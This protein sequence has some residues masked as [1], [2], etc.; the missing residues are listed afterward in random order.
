MGARG[1][2]TEHPAPKEWEIKSQSFIF[3]A[4]TENKKSL[5]SKKN[6]FHLGLTAVFCSHGV[7]QGCTTEELLW[8]HKSFGH[9]TSLTLA[10][11]PATWPGLRI[12]RTLCGT[13]E[14]LA[15][16]KLIGTS[17]F[18]ALPWLPH[19]PTS[20]S[21]GTWDLCQLFCLWTTPDRPHCPCD[22]QNPKHNPKD[23]PSFELK[24]KQL[25]LCPLLWSWVLPPPLW[26]PCDF[27][28]SASLQKSSLQRRMLQQIQLSRKGSFH[29]PAEDSTFQLL[30]C[31]QGAVSA[32]TDGCSTAMSQLGLGDFSCGE[33][34]DTQKGHIKYRDD[35]MNPL[36]TSG[37][38]A[39]DRFASIVCGRE[40]WTNTFKLL[41]YFCLL[42]NHC[43][44]ANPYGVCLCH[45]HHST[46]K[47]HKGFQVG[48]LQC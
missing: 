48:S 18:A 5:V 13:C 19:A 35:F 32:V 28:I 12:S 23:T 44:T 1:G 27:Y 2:A 45:L 15:W 7:V 6:H 3:E 31:K 29:V 17:E 26:Y 36:K 37:C 11:K 22:A 41:Q 24:S 10:L 21:A 16:V 30:W 43:L 8:A 20:P 39:R 38:G 25:P 9:C 40:V 46:W 33:E 42:L 4:E 47:L 34:A 14:C